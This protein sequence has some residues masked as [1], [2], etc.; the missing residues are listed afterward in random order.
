M[1]SFLSDE[2]LSED[3]ELVVLEAVLLGFIS[4]TSLLFILVGSGWKM[5]GVPFE[6]SWNGSNCFE[7]VAPNGSSKLETSWNKSLVIGLGNGSTVFADDD[8]NTSRFFWEDMPKRSFVVE[9][10][11][12][13]K[14]SLL[15]VRTAWNKSPLVV[16]VR[17]GFPNAGCGE[18]NRSSSLSEE[19]LN[20]STKI[21][22]D[23]SKRFSS[24]GRSAWSEWS[25]LAAWKRLTPSFLNRSVLSDFRFLDKFCLWAGTGLNKSGE[26]N[27]TS[28]KWPLADWFWANVDARK[29]SCTGLGVRTWNRS[30]WCSEN[31]SP[32]STVLTSVWRSRGELWNSGGGTKMVLKLMSELSFPTSSWLLLPDSWQQSKKSLGMC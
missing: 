29:R 28:W 23:F 14:G 8:E 19:D 7:G 11:C 21:L 26:F 30:F 2:L 12:L 17:N 20:G 1:S 13:A 6:R 18:R 16:A 9:G 24:L 15:S 10:S 3:I 31:L 25:P 27:V 5:S 4:N 22:A 32:C